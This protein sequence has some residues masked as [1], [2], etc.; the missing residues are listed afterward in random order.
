MDVLGS[1]RFESH[2]MQGRQFPVS[3]RTF[4]APMR[5]VSTAPLG[6]GFGIRHHWWNAQVPSDYPGHDVDADVVAIAR[7]LGVD[8]ADAV[9][10]LTAVD[11]RDEWHGADGG[12]E[13]VATVG[14]THP[15]WAAVREQAHD[16]ANDVAVAG[17]INVF[18][19][20]PARLG[21]AALVNAACTATEA[22]AQAL[23]EAGIAGTGT[24]SDALAVA[25]RLDG[26]PHTYGGPRS[27]WGA[28][29]ARAVHGAVRDG[30]ARRPESGP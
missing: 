25:A 3:L 15:A 13:V 19:A 11:V 27:R 21:D 7:C 20:V 28:R 6:G 1:V 26:R 9:G 22:K 12:V 17:T 24:A 18:V 5:V 16:P 2:S 29:V 4:P 8:P 10:M 23:V 14:V 30:L